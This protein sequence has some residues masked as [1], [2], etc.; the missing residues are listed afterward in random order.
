MRQRYSISEEEYEKTI[1]RLQE[2][3]QNEPQIIFAYLH[4]SF[5]ERSNFG[6]LDLALF[7]NEIPEKE[8]MSY[9]FDLERLIERVLAY[10]VDVR[11]LNNAPS[12]FCYTVIKKGIRLIDNNEDER[13]NFEMQTYQNYFDFLP[14]RR[15]YLK[16]AFTHEI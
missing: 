9:E 2:M 16:E 14:F 6:D 7:V 10:P 8:F 3:I 11:I 4:G 15:R 1:K 13:V 5:I 12:S